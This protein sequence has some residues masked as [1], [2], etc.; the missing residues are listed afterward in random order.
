MHEVKRHAV[1]LS[2]CFPSTGNALLMVVVESLAAQSASVNQDDYDFS[3]NCLFALLACV[4]NLDAIR[5][6]IDACRSP[7]H[8][9]G[10]VEIDLKNLANVIKTILA[11][12]WVLVYNLPFLGPILGPSGFYF[13]SLRVTADPL[14]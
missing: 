12:V 8:N 3:H 10:E 6:D 11:A 7:H 13:C 14:S 2:M 4:T 1:M 5:S 9:K